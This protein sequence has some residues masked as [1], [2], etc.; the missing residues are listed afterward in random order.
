MHIRHQDHSSYVHIE[1]SNKDNGDNTDPGESIRLS[2]T[3]YQQKK[4]TNGLMPYSFFMIQYDSKQVG[5]DILGITE[6]KVV[7]NPG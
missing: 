2:T 3:W 1:S 4:I 7:K 5:E 6:R